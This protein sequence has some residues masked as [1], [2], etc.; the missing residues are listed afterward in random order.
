MDAEAEGERRREQAALIVGD[1]PT[2]RDM[3]DNVRFPVTDRLQVEHVAEP[4]LLSLRAGRDLEAALHGGPVHR[5]TERD[6][7]RA[8]GR[9]V[10]A[11]SGSDPDDPGMRGLAADQDDTD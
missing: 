8:A 4:G 1:R 9:V 11:A 7:G 6:L 3:V 10:V 2:E 5:L